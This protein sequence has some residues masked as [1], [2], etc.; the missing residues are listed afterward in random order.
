MTLRRVGLLM[1]SVVLQACAHGIAPVRAAPERTAASPNTLP[2]AELVASRVDQFISPHV[3]MRDFSGTILLARRGHVLFSR[4]YGYADF[5]RGIT[6]DD[7]TRYG[8]GSVTK[9]VTAAAIELLAA[10]GLL[11]L[12]D[13]ITKYLPGFVHGDSITITNLL[14]HSSGLKDY[15]AWPLYASDRAR[16]I[17]QREFLAH[18]QT[19]P[20]DFSPGTKSSY[21]NSGYS[22]LAAIIE[23]VSGMPYRDF[24]RRNL[25]LPLGMQA[26]DDF[27]DGVS[28][29]RLAKGYD[30]GLSASRVQL[31]ANVSRSWLEGSGSVYAT[32]PDLYRW[33]QAIRDETITKTR[34]LLYPFGWGKC[35]RFGRQLIEQNGRVP[36]G[37]SS[38][39]ALYP[40]DDLIVIVLSNIQSEVTEVLGTGLAAIALGQN[41]E[42]PRLRVSYTA[43]LQADS[44]T[45]AAYTG[46]YEIAPGFVLA[47]RAMPQGIL[48]AGPDGA[49][50]PLDHEGADRFFFRTLYVPLAFERD[51]SGR[52]ISLNW[53]GQFKAKRLGTP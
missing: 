48:I 46:Q 12:S 17:S 23:R 14:E 3:A 37:Y 52:I 2:A 13:P 35:T 42:V 44:V 40:D 4:A 5:E 41:Y 39:V 38:Y 26:V 50:L 10:R 34:A 49:F 18:L 6:P 36:I 45:F 22:V 25:F 9:T 51:S 30:A 8:I 47:V 15:Y 16:P 11:S 28:V 27:Q 31:A 33:L 7:S 43:P 32:A 53:N 19:Q 21:S 24:I 1:T 20:V 29:T